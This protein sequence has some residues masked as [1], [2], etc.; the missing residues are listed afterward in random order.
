MSEI[1][2]PED[3]CEE[4]GHPIYQHGEGGCEGASGLCCCTAYEFE[5]E[6]PEEME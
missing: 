1:R 5:P 3:P 4:C 2:N 6:D